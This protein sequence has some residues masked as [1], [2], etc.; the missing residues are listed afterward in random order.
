MFA[1]FGMYYIILVLVKISAIITTVKK[2][3]LRQDHNFIISLTLI[4]LHSENKYYIKL[5]KE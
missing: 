5:Q 4:Y 3:F 1:K 2:Y